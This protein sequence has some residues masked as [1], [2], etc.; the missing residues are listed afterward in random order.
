MNTCD[1]NLKC[2]IF[3][4]YTQAFHYS[5][6]LHHL[7]VV[8]FCPLYS[9]CPFLP[10]IPLRRDLAPLHFFWKSKELLD[11]G[12]LYRHTQEALLKPRLNPTLL[13]LTLQTSMHSKSS[14][15]SWILCCTLTPQRHSKHCTGWYSNPGSVTMSQGEILHCFCS[16]YPEERRTIGHLK[17]VLLGSEIISPHY[18][19]LEVVFP[20]HAAVFD[21]RRQ[22]VL[23][24]SHMS[25]QHCS[26]FCSD[27]LTRKENC[28]TRKPSIWDDFVVALS[29]VAW[30]FSLDHMAPRSS[31]F[32]P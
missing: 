14:L 11:S 30:K 4:Y 6:L 3:I 13:C 24:Q 8:I 16:E 18:M 17:L 29:P 19:L 20:F 1:Q 27:L 22:T 2:D 26:L 7:R 12:L 25:L 23:L 32:A 9:N 31:F 10:A 5:S 15:I 21:I 28:E